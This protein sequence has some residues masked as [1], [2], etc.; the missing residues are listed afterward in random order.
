MHR[1]KALIYGVGAMAR[2]YMVKF[3]VEKGVDI[4]GAVART[5]NIGKDL[6]EVCGL[7]RSL[8]VEISDDVDEVI[9]SR[10]IDIAVIT[11]KSLMRD[12]FDQIAKCVSHGINV[13][14]ICEEALYPWHTSPVI[15][16]K[17]DKLAKENGV[18]ITGSG[19]QDVYFTNMI[20]QLAGTCQRIDSI[21]GTARYNINDYG[22]E[23]AR[24]H[25]V[26]D[27]EAQFHK[28]IE[29]EGPLPSF[30]RNCAE[31]MCANMGLTIIRC[32]ASCEPL[33]DEVDIYAKS[34]G[35]TIPAGR[36]VGCSDIC[37]IDTEQG[38]KIKTVMMGKCYKKG[39]VDINKWEIHD[40]NLNT[41]VENCSPPTDVATCATVVNR[42]PDVI[43]AEP[44]FITCE[45]L[46]QLQYRVYPLHYYL[47]R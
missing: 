21:T 35:R 36:L 45:K 34:L 39:E 40:G 25:Y 1:I 17:L 8:G 33:K 28:K 10:Q 38:V 16:A 18:T 43:N 24:L 32:V 13:I 23:V 5:S 42:I 7:G 12:T 26:G 29:K 41:N 4:V 22:P 30:L 37:E 27:T 47:K 6:G 31:A 2:T 19:Y 9:S 15:T 44:G 11:T 20:T 14:T 3:M 46:P